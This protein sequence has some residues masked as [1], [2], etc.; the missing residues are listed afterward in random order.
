MRG[1]VHRLE[2]VDLM[3]V[4]LF[5]LHRHLEHVICIV[6]GIGKAIISVQAMEATLCVG[7][8]ACVRMCVHA[9][10]CVCVCARACV[11][12]SVCMSVCVCLCVCA[13]VCWKG[14]LIE[15]CWHSRC[16][17]PE[18]SQSRELNMFG[19]MTWR[20]GRIWRHS[21]HCNKN[22]YKAM[23]TRNRGVWC[24]HNTNTHMHMHMLTRS[25]Y[26]HFHTHTNI[27]T[28]TATH[29][30]IVTSSKPRSMYDDRMNSIKVR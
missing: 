4:S 28:Y 22:G 25:Q 11:C 30:P 20:A 29:G 2:S 14:R 19:V 1:T 17:C 10:A 16:Q 6:C 21:E 26:P 23:P 7:V 13:C 12:M 9:C 8:C 5:V 3:D 27:Y 18:V 15:Q 24:T